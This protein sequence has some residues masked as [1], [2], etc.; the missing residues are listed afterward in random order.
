[1]KQLTI[2]QDELGYYDSEGS[3]IIARQQLKPLYQRNGI[4]YVI[5]RRCLLD[6]G[7]IKGERTGAY[8]V[9]EPSV[10]IDT[11]YDIELVE[12]LMEKNGD[13]LKLDSIKYVKS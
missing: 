1:L 5:N 7:N 10:S 13:P 9:V 3:E 11:V 4:I 2:E 6:H 12:Y 8:I